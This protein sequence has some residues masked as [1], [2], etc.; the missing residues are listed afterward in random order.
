MIENPTDFSTTESGYAL[1]QSFFSA[2]YSSTAI[3]AATDSLALGVLQAADEAGV[4]I[5]ED[6]SLL[7]FDNCFYGDLPKIKLST[8][9]QCKQKLAEAAVDLLLQ[10]IDRPAE[11]PA[12]FSRRIIRPALVERATCI[13]H[14]TE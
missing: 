14:R 11:E 6:L 1:A 5:P 8:V 4:R 9:D 2:P 7:G 3:F 13:P 10:L 12:E